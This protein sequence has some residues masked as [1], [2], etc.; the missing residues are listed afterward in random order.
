MIFFR[1][2]PFLW[3]LSVSFGMIFFVSSS[4]ADPEIRY[5][6]TGKRDPFVSLASSGVQT[7][8]SLLN[9]ESLDEIV[10]QGIVYDPKQG[11]MAM[12]NGVFLKEGEETG[13]VKLVKV[14][15][16]SVVFSVNGVEGTKSL[17][18]RE[19]LDKEAT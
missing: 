18:P 15:P 13:S 14:K 19:S 2:E 5:R 9:V 7:G 16:D 4:F 3:I 12:A 6:A 8:A 1:R 17:Y 10:I 11:S